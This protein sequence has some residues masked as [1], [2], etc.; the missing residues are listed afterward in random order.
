MTRAGNH[1]T[2]ILI[3]NIVGTWGDGNPAPGGWGVWNVVRV[4]S[5]RVV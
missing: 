2:S 3:K 4:S 1:A 5:F